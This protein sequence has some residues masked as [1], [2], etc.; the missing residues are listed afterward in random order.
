M[1]DKFI[2]EYTYSEEMIRESLLAKWYDKNK[3]VYIAIALFIVVMLV[4]AVVK[5]NWIFLIFV[6]LFIALG[7]FYELIKK[8]TVNED[9]EKAQGLYEDGATSIRVEISDVIRAKSAS[10][11]K[12]IQYSD[13]TKLIN[14][15]NL[16][17][18]VLKGGTTFT[19]SKDGFIS[20]DAVECLQ[21][22]KKKV[23]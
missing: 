20:G 6:A 14:S 13:V 11:E 7:A 19:L 3:K 4:M 1:V 9:V 10:N 2:N 5:R 23:R 15:K 18:I 12:E 22:L 16:I 8:R 21:Y 17:L